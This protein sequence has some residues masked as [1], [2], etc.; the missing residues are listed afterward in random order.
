MEL[1]DG[2]KNVT[3]VVRNSMVYP[4]TLRKKTPVVR[5]VAPTWVPE[6]PVQ[7]GV[8]EELNEAHD[9]QA[10][11]LLMKQRQKKLFEELDLNWLESWPPKLADSTKSLLAEY[12]DI[13]S[14]EPSELICT[15]STEHVIKVNN[16]TPFKEWFRWIHLQLVEVVHMHMWEMLDSGVIHPSQ[17]VWCNVVVLVQKKDRCLWFCI[18]FHHLNALTKKDSYL[19]PRIQEV[20]ESLV[21]AGHFSCLDLKSGFWQIKLDE[22]S[23]QYTGIYCWQFGLLWVWL[24][25][26][27]AVQCT[28]HVSVANAK[29]PRG[30]ESNILP[31]VPWWHSCL[32]ADSWGTSP[33]LMHHLLIDL[34]NII[35]NWSHLNATF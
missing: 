29:L 30:A 17:S 10:P 5:A 33:L 23:K 4:Q 32:L 31:H 25:A 1:C 15:H 21:G 20:L 13:F 16:N 22:L 35:W 12:H 8:I 34:E 28:S 27:W 26:F 18:D 7:T 11:R 14:L 2:S 24:H 19:L 6:P 9:P 3:V